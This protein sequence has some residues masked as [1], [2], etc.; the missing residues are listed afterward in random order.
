[1]SN[2]IIL[3][4]MIL[5]ACCVLLIISVFFSSE[6]IRLVE[7]NFN[8][9]R[10]VLIK[11]N[12]GL[13]DKIGS[14]E[15]AVSRS[16]AERAKDEERANTI[17]GEFVRIKE[18]REDAKAE[19]ERLAKKLDSSSEENR[20]LTEQLK[21]LKNKPSA[22]V[23][24][25]GNVKKVLPIQDAPELIGK[26][27]SG[28]IKKVS[29]EPPSQKVQSMQPI[30]LPEIKGNIISIDFRNNLAVIDRGRKDSIKELNRCIILKD[31]QEFAR[32]EV[33]MVGYG[34][35]TI[36]INEVKYNSTISD[37]PERSAVIVQSS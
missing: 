5:A 2:K 36:F 25:F 8:K 23:V 37:I 12:L 24:D 19:Y 21:A 30:G 1:M 34:T 15:E 20:Y 27:Q 11:E 26:E 9:K 13:K 7:L 17:E 29:Q 35:S 22:P 6:R 10:V 18:E 33:I 14:F 3:N 16:A 31:D 32:G 4:I 28:E